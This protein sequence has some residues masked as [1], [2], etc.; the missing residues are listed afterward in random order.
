MKYFAQINFVIEADSYEQAS[1][2]QEQ[3]RLLV[4]GHMWVTEANAD[5][6]VE[7]DEFGHAG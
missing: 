2:L 7:A 5:E 4:Q 1:N 3:S 6:T